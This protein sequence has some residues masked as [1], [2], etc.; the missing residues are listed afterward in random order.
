MIFGRKRRQVLGEENRTLS[1]QLSRC[2][3][4]IDVLHCMSEM[5]EHPPFEGEAF[6]QHL[7][8]QL[9]LKLNDFG[10]YSLLLRIDGHSYTNE[11]FS[12]D[13]QSVTSSISNGEG[14]A[15]FMS[16]Y[17]HQ[18]LE[19]AESQEDIAA[20]NSVIELFFSLV[21]RLSSYVTRQ[22][23]EREQS[24]QQEMFQTILRYSPDGIVV[25]D[26]RGTVMQ[27]SEQLA[28]IFGYPNAS[29]LV[30][31]P[32]LELIHPDQRT[33]AESS[34]AQLLSGTPVEALEY[35][36]KRSD[37]SLVDIEV[38]ASLIR[39]AQGTSQQMVT[40]IRD[41]S[42]RKGMEHRLQ[43]SEARFKSLI[44]QIHEVIFEIN[45]QAQ[46]LY[47]SP[48]VQHLLGY[49]SEQILDASLIELAIRE[50]RSVALGALER[51]HE[52]EH[53]D[54]QLRLHH[55]DG[56]YRW[57]RCS[58]APIFQGAS[59]VGGRGSL[60]DI[61]RQ[62]RAEMELV[63]RES[64]LENLV[65]FQTNY[66]MRT[67]LDGNI[68]YA[69]PRFIRDFAW[70][71]DDRGE[72]IIGSNSL[73]CIVPEHHGRMEQAV[74]KC[75]ENPGKV[76]Q[77]ELDK[78]VKSGRVLNTLWEIVAVLDQEEHPR[79]IQC[80]GVDISDRIRAE[81]KLQE[82]EE[83][84]RTLF[85]KSPDGYLILKDR[86]YVECNKT[87]RKMLG[88][89][90]KDIIGK[91]PED[92]SPEFQPN[93]RK[94]SEWAK[95]IF[96]ETEKK[97]S[98]IFT[99]YHSHKNGHSVCFQVN[100]NSLLYQGEDA[101]LVT[102]RDIT[103]QRR[104]EEQ[105]T[106]L[107]QAVE[108]SPVS[109]IITDTTGRIEYANPMACESS[110]YRIDELMG[111]NPRLLKSGQTDE[112]TYRQ[113]WELISSGEQWRGQFYNKR[114]NGQLYWESA[115]VGPVL[116]DM[117]V[118]AHF[119]AVK[120]DISQR[121]EMQKELEMNQSRLIR[122]T[123]QSRTII[124]E[125]DE[126]GMYS[127]VSP[128]MEHVLGYEPNDL[129]GRKCIWDFTPEHLRQRL[130]EAYLA[131]GASGES[132]QNFDNQR[133]CSDGSIRWFSTSASPVYDQQG[134]LAGIQGADIDIT[135]RLSGEQEIRKLSA[136][137]EQSPVAIAIA[138]LRGTI[139][140]VSPA[141]VELTG[142]EHE[143]VTG[144]PMSEIF[145]QAEQGLDFGRELYQHMWQAVS[146]GELWKGEWVNVRKS[147]QS[148]PESTLVAPIFD[149]L[150]QIIN[151]IIIKHDMSSQKQAADERIAR[152]SAE[153]A[154]QAKS[155]FLSNM[156]HEI[157]TPLNAIIGFSQ[158][159]LKDSRLTSEQME[160]VSTIS[161]SG[162]HLLSLIND[163][164]DLSKIEAGRVLIV[165][166][167]FDLFAMVADLNM[168]FELQTRKRG[169]GLFIDIGQDIP[170]VLRGDE[171]KLR[172][173]LINLLN[174]AV[175][176][177]HEGQV[178]LKLRRVSL[179]GS[180]IRVRFDVTDSGS[181]IARED[182]EL[183]FHAF[184]QTFGGHRA[185]GTGLGLS[186]S[187][188]LAELL[189]GYLDAESVLG[190]GSTFSLELPFQTPEH[191]EIRGK[192]DPYERVLMLDSG[193][194][195]Q[196]VLV[197]DDLPENRL[198][199]EELLSPVGFDIRL[200]N[201]GRQAVQ[202]AKDW[203]PDIVLMD[204][205]MPE[206]DGYQATEEIRAMQRQG[207][208]N[209]SMKVVAVTASVFE[210]ELVSRASDM[211]DEYLLKPF[212]SGDLFRLLAEVLG[213]RY[214]FQ[215]EDQ[216]NTAKGTRA[217]VFREDVH[218][219]PMDIRSQM[220]EAIRQGEIARMRQLLEELKDVDRR[221]IDELERLAGLYDYDT[222]LDLLQ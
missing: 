48:A 193:S 90:L 159:L 185:G 114:K 81:H 65:N 158:I 2:R 21:Q 43:R 95:R 105:L 136:A 4:E 167:D 218:A 85:D 128:A 94:S 55:V 42:F 145:S 210:D 214:E 33:R 106:I 205:R 123:E 14:E 77:V 13:G 18:D 39:N 216:L 186:I 147:G 10:P 72:E 32:L 206:T 36:G 127:Y 11:K 62:K 213:V 19:H 119:V 179:P 170:R 112:H 111:A 7:T 139:E 3:C 191:G 141:Y 135:D 115:S 222:L 23:W 171:K 183:V 69:N 204:L 125:A 113:M 97:G 168:M 164:L 78:L 150:R 70:V 20:H 27:A 188:N 165:R 200:V 149:Q 138:D 140:Y 133:V 103:Q 129:V 88:M 5:L 130:R 108:Q 187:R 8:N 173:I 86:L 63:N 25:C 152:E 12:S 132:M 124:W 121:L 202:E 197:A 102:W 166:E 134:G 198:L 184:A 44:E 87:A 101:F 180:A 45:L 59:V 46:F 209:A 192:D 154:N 195:P 122:A 37:G 208:V 57:I 60:S 163:I 190:T 162:E 92:I 66:V 142:Y 73:H 22:R 196:R 174:N 212:K 24:E 75:L 189:G 109:I 178:E 84:Y 182:L 83:K 176:F 172:Q 215:H 137:I 30:G 151:F 201:D 82:S 56:S 67:D 120:E 118:I 110:G 71:F 51:L 131:I 58:I 99:W 157:R 211:F 175:K 74:A 181:G 29:S 155:M 15:G 100:L 161:R 117:G 17:L 177:T 54:I 146:R 35:L 203:D 89:S 34:F 96:E 116:N 64:M 38:N 76:I 156:S 31:K 40:V 207:E 160:R 9:A 80:M 26:T 41:I 219:I 220:A 52:G 49:R 50:Q 6:F 107:S 28:R 53:I 221:V 79:E 194:L 98:N 68:S 217:P 61:H 1:K 93:G 144:S 126:A 143:E 91:G 16:L 104:A 148:Y 153:Q 169:I 47:A 199:I